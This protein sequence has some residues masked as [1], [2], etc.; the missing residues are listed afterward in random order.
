[1]VCSKLQQ[2]GILYISLQN[3]HSYTIVGKIRECH[4]LPYLV[5]EVPV[6]SGIYHDLPSPT[7]KGRKKKTMI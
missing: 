3:T 7:P 5:P 4:V 6:A 1:M 2:S